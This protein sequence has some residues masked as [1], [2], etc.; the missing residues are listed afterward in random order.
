MPA[1]KKN[2][3]N[4]YHEGQRSLTFQVI[5]KITKS[6]TEDYFY[7]VQIIFYYKDLFQFLDCSDD[8]MVIYP[9]Q[10]ISNYLNI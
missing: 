6:K 4:I 2:K 1:S 7:D 3:I 5:Y 9:F 10:N 8:F